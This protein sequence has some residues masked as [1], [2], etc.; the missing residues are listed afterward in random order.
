M[1]HHIPVHSLLA[2][3]PI[4]F[5]PDVLFDGSWSTFDSTCPGILLHPTI[6]LRKDGDGI[7][8]DRIRG[9]RFG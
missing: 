2:A 4:I 5:F 1:V 7:D 8:Q 3:H 6:M 9:K